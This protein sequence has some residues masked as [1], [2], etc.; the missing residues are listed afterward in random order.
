MNF[1]QALKNFNTCD[2]VIAGF[3]CLLILGVFLFCSQSAKQMGHVLE[4]AMIDVR[5]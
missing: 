3:A 5:R 4:R 2:K 1:L